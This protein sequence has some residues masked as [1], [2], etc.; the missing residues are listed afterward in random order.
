MM[1]YNLLILSIIMFLFSFVFILYSLYMYMELFYLILEWDILYFMSMKFSYMLF[2]DFY[3]MMFLSIIMLIS[4]MVMLY[5][6]EYMNF[7]KTIMRFNY[8]LILFIISM[9]LMILSPSILSIMLGW[10]GLGL[11][12][13]CLVIYYHSMVSL[14][15][16]MLTIMCNRLGDIGL[17]M[18]I[19]LC[20]IYGSWNLMLYWF[21][22]SLISLMLILSALTKSAQMP[23]SSWLPAAMTAPTPVSSLVHSSTLVT[24][25]VYLLIRF[26]NFINY[27]NL[28]IYLLY[29]FI[30][31][32]FMSGIM[33]NFE[34]D[35]KKIIALST[36]SQLS[37][38]MM[39]LMINMNELAFFHLIIHALFKSLMFLCAG[40]FIHFMNGDQDIRNYKGMIYMY[41][42]K[43]LIMMFSLFSLMGFPYLSGFY[44]KDLIIEIMM[45][46]KLSNLFI[47]MFFF[48]MLLTISYSVRLIMFLMMNN[49]NF[50]S[51]MNYNSSVIMIICMFILFNYMIFYG[52]NFFNL[53][54]NKFYFFMMMLDKLLV[55]EFYMLG[56]YLGLYFYLNKLIM[57]NMMFFISNMFFL[58][59]F[60]KIIYLD[61]FKFIYKYEF[62][63]EKGW[64]EWMMGLYFKKMINLLYYIKFYNKIELN[65][66]ILLYFL[67]ILF[68]FFMIM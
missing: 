35:L 36:L 30:L 46:Y 2:L 1:L 49:F 12:S 29:L 16:G 33:A 9:C 4:S 10:D 26:N 32:M 17:L 40:D 20:S 37:F 8:L 58:N 51:Y 23:F 47:Y 55:L 25:G 65:Y 42:L 41:P 11:I 64:M 45:N 21:D 61:M 39:V 57:Y 31:T 44:S 14:N 68:L 19:C 15:S 28:N 27:M 3:S 48:S 59:N 34:F 38:M 18:G 7:D 5:S 6:L 60:F 66:L 54:F 24:A 62:V 50:M 56:I 67:M 52:Y 13:Y 53:M 63:I 22:F 43:S